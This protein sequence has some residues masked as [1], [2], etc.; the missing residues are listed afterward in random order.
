M[1]RFKI[2]FQKLASELHDMKL[3]CVKRGEKGRQTE[4]HI[5]RDRQTEKQMEKWRKKERKRQTYKHTE[6]Q[7]KRYTQRAGKGRKER[8]K[9]KVLLLL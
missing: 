4:R 7:K 9:T 3:I 8:R 1:I 5:E 6:R 2:R